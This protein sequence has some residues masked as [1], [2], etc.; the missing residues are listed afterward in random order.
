MP[1]PHAK[2]ILLAAV[3]ACT[4]AGARC[5]DLTAD[6]RAAGWKLLFDG[7]TTSGWHRIGKNERPGNA[8]IAQ[9]GELKLVKTLGVTGGGDIVTDE[10]FEDFELIW[11]WKIAPD[12]NS[13][14]KY[15]LPD[16]SRA[17]GCEYQ[18][19]DDAKNSDAK[20]HNR[21]HVTASLYDMFAPPPDAK[22]NP[23][24]EWNMGRIVVQGNHVEHYL[25]GVKVV[26]YDFGSDVFQKAMAE[27]KFKEAP[28]WGIKTK[29]SILLQDHN[30]EVS[31]RNVRI[32]PG[33]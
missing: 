24:G 21:T 20:V 31:F 25:N 22:L 29:S 28:G 32:R 6:E 12:G 18:L 26:S 4:A 10:M 8:W 7:T 13:G 5:A 11:E 1:L 15:N 2:C 27:S 19:L 17:I 9:D 33:Y 16:P 14:V 3:L 30:S 23:A